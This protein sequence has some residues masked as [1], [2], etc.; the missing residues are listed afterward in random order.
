[1]RFFQN[2]GSL[3]VHEDRHFESFKQWR[4]SVCNLCGVVWHNEAD[5][6]LS[7][8][9]LNFQDETK[10]VGSCSR[11]I[12]NGVGQTS[13]CTINEGYC[14]KSEYDNSSCSDLD[15][16]SSSSGTEVGSLSQRAVIALGITEH[17]E[18]T[19][20]AEYRQGCLS[21]WKTFSVGRQS[22]LPLNSRAKSLLLNSADKLAVGTIKNSSPLRSDVFLDSKS[23]SSMQHKCVT[24]FRCFTY[25]QISSA[26]NSFH[27][28]NLVGKGGYAEVYKGS[29]PNGQLV[30]V[31]RLT[32][33]ESEDLKERAFLTELGIIV[34]VSHPNAS[35]LI[36]FCIE[37]GM[38]LVFPFLPL[39]SLSSSLHGPKAQTLEWPIRYKVAVGVARGLHYL[40][41]CCQR[42]IIHRD[43]KAS[44]ILLGPDYEP[45]ISD[46]GLAKWLPAQWTHHTVTAIEGT[47]GYTAPEYS[48]HGIVDEKTDVFAFGILLLELVTGRR[49]VASCKQNTLVWAQPFLETCN[50]EELV[51]HRLCG[52]YDSHELQRILITAAMCVRQSAIW[53]PCMTKVLKLL[54][55]AG[56]DQES[57]N[58]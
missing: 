42:R 27:P 32:K 31:K 45:Q 1:M 52:V 55:D 41:K 33:G 39:G 26:T 51:D 3:K 29:L 20:P 19:T 38:H 34:H 30:A 48:M 35:S 17:N 54:M 13:H 12:S 18:L 49:P 37:G 50:V 36:G 53:R 57:P 2:E 4:K 15:G 6:T 8:E 10:T 9:N 16:C 11:D 21:L 47:Y 7:P 44:N 23:L 22:S 24:P 40:H 14:S 46:F 58:Q 43:I 5:Y 56:I 28:D 25:A